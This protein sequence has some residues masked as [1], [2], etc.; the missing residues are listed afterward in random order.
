[1]HNLSFLFL[2]V[3]RSLSYNNNNWKGKECDRFCIYGACLSS[4]DHVYDIR[5]IGIA[6]DSS[7]SDAICVWWNNRETKNH[8]QYKSFILCLAAETFSRGGIH[9]LNKYTRTKTHTQVFTILGL[10]NFWQSHKQT[11]ERMNRKLNCKVNATHCQTRIWFAFQ[12]HT[13]FWMAAN[14][15]SFQRIERKIVI[16]SI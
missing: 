10:L 9:T 1:M 7:Q 6:H 11:N 3:R 2:S 8:I 12:L 14:G 5:V 13:I 15:F 16:H 4:T